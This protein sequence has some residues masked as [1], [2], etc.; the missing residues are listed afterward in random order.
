MP[1]AGGLAVAGTGRRRGAGGPVAGADAERA[2]VRS[3]APVPPP[4]TRGPAA[5]EASG[6]GDE[7]MTRA[8]IV[9]ASYSCRALA[10]CSVRAL[11]ALPQRGQPPPQAQ[12]R[13]GDSRSADFGSGAMACEAIGGFAIARAAGL[14]AAVP[15]LARA[16]VM[17]HAPR[18]FT[19]GL[20]RS[21]C[22]AIA[23]IEWAAAGRSRRAASSRAP[24]A[25]PPGS[26]H[27]VSGRSALRRRRPA[28]PRH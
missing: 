24:R 10:G 16:A 25:R 3:R 23:W 11:P 8:P 1:R 9:L 19:S 18:E 7:R 27:P 12:R 28:V 2:R 21:A 14:I 20:T 22:A 17:L 15:A 6:R 4:G 5:V 26:G 13:R